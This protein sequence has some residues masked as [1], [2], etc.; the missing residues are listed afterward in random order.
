ML[1]SFSSLSAFMNGPSHVPQPYRHNSEPCM[2][3]QSEQRIN[4]HARDSLYLL[5]DAVER[6]V[7]PQQEPVENCPQS[8]DLAKTIRTSPTECS[9]FIKTAPPNHSTISES[10]LSCASSIAHLVDS[11]TPSPHPLVNNPTFQN[12]P[13]SKNSIQNLIFDSNDMD[14]APFFPQCQPVK[15]YEPTSSIQE[16]QFLPKHPN[17]SRLHTQQQRALSLPLYPAPIEF[18]HSASVNGASD[19]FTRGATPSKRFECPYPSCTKL[20]SS[21]NSLRSHIRCH[22]EAIYQCSEC[23]SSFRLLQVQALPA[24]SAT[25]IPSPSSTFF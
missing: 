25:F 24:I 13:A 2:Y 10:F 21:A 3:Q 14:D 11:L 15:S 22:T 1:P 17:Q 4:S 6:S 20:C 7:S 18:P 8:S 5:V 19:K 9:N 23:P 12:Q 16:F